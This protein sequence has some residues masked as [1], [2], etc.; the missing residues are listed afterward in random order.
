MYLD[1]ELNS[2]GQW[3]PVDVER[4]IEIQFNNLEPGDYKL[5]IRKRNG[6]GRDNFSY[7][8]LAIYIDAPW[9]K[10]WWFYILSIFAAAGL[11]RLYVRVRTTQLRLKQLRLEQQVAEKTKEL[12]F[13]NRVLEKNDRIKTRLISII[14]HDI[15]T[16]LKFL[17]VAGKNLIEKRELMSE[18]LQHET[19]LE[20][21]S[22]S[23]ELQLLSTNILNWIK[24]Q[25]E[26]G[27]S[28]KKTNAHELCNQVR[29]LKSL[30][31]Q[32]SL[33]IKEISPELTVHQYYEPQD[34]IYNLVSDTIISLTVGISSLEIP[35]WRNNLVV[36][37]E[38]VGMTSEQIQNIMG[39]QFIVSS[40]M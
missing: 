6:F 31:N 5:L 27:D 10:Q 33:F 40:A 35:Q 11:F 18:H 12:Q 19:L 17:T 29:C 20:I 23:L 34:P 2:D 32:R 37:D 1:Y 38:G 24:Y 14:S 21:T 39:D 3:R 16:P 15:V 4:G 28:Q 25:T 30:A 26:N 9:Y 13:K 7:K 36:K 8:A 22:T